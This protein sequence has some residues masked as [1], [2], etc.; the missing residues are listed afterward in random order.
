MFLHVSVILSRGGRA[1]QTGV[2]G[3]GACVGGVHGRGVHGRGHVW[4]GGMHG[5][6]HAWQGEMHGR[7]RAWWGVVHA[8]HAPQQILRLRHMVNEWTV[9]IL[10]E[11]IL[12]N[13]TIQYKS[14]TVH[15]L[16]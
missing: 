5:R 4:P 10:L 12:V 1:W 8:T 11:C 15:T 2:C 6:G 13:L 7:G 16:N 3:K 14:I 9:R